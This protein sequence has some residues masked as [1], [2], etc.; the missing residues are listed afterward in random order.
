MLEE[1]YEEVKG[2]G[3]T[4]STRRGMGP[5]Y[6]DKVSY[7][8]IRLADFADQALL[9]EKLRIQLGVK[10]RLFESFGMAPLV[11]EAVVQE[12]LAQYD[13]LRS[14]VREPF[15]LLQD[16]TEARGGDPAGGR[17]GSPFG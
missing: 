11:L 16:G 13:Q 3:A 4:G 5:V 2:S 8:A 1:I 12:K 9:T 15:G 7:N 14:A 10:N 17:A 6:A